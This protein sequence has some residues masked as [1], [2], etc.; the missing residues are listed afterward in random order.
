MSPTRS[1]WLL[2]LHSHQRLVSLGVGTPSLKRVGTH[3]AFLRGD[4]HLPLPHTALTELLVYKCL[5]LRCSLPSGHGRVPST[6]PQQPGPGPCGRRRPLG[7]H[8]PPGGAEPGPPQPHGGPALPRK[9]SAGLGT[10]RQ[11]PARLCWAVLCW[12]GLGW[13]M[14]ESPEEVAVLVQ[15]VVKDIRNAFARNPHM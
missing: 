12:A 1:F 7:R 13:K 2:T 9:S 8:Q 6:P 15:R 11:G 3:S 10:A 4:I 5:R 14:A